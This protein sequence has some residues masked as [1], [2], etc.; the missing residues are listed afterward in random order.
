MTWNDMRKPG[1]IPGLVEPA[2][3]PMREHELGDLGFGVLSRPEMAKES[4]P[5]TRYTLFPLTQM[6]AWIGTIT[7][8]MFKTYLRICAREPLV[9]ADTLRQG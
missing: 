4:Y 2:V 7:F 8:P 3:K 5:E 6:I 1:K 9:E